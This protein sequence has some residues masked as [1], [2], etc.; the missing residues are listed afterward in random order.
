MDNLRE[1]H[2]PCISYTL[3][4]EGVFM[5][6]E[7][8]LLHIFNFYFFPLRFFLNFLF[9]L[10]LS[11]LGLQLKSFLCLQQAEGSSSCGAPASHCDGFSCCR[12][13]VIGAWAR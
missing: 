6:K 12:A 9:I 11:A 4:V 13:W 1:N 3:S 2:S 7:H 8:S 5:G 10:F